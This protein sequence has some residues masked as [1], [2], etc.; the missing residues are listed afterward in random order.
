[1]EFRPS[2]MGA[3]ASVTSQRCGCGGA[4]AVLYV[5]WEIDNIPV[6]LDTV[7][8]CVLCSENVDVRE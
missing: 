3:D 7:Y 5:A 4:V 1:M 2:L 8:V 6:S